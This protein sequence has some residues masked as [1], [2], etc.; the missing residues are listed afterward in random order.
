MGGDRR[1]RL[2]HADDASED[3]LV[4]DEPERSAV[5][6]VAAIVT[7]DEHVPERHALR[8]EVRTSVR[9]RVSSGNVPRIPPLALFGAVGLTA[10]AIGNPRA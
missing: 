9:A 4:A 5:A 3:A 2:E 8:S 6:T 1:S 10:P 7:E